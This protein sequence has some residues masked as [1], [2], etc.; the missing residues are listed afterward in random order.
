[1]EFGFEIDTKLAEEGEWRDFGHLLPGLRVKLRGTTSEAFTRCQ[2]R[3]NARLRKMRMTEGKRIEAHANAYREA[4]AEAVLLD[5]EGL[6]DRQTGDVVPFS[7]ALALE[8]MTEKR[9][10][11]FASAVISEATQIG[12]ADLEALEEH[13]GNSERA[14]ASTS[15]PAPSIPRSVTHSKRSAS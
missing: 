10:E 4:I 9:H 3:K 1:M 7:A 14:S 11:L 5:I 8:L 15:K 13:A 2:E 12:L 6:V